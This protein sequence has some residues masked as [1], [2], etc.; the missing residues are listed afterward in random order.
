M[1]IRLGSTNEIVGTDAG[2]ACSTTTDIAS[3]SSIRLQEP[4]LSRMDAERYSLNTGHLVGPRQT[5]RI[6][7]QLCH[8]DDLARSPDLDLDRSDDASD[9]DSFR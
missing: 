4:R 1:S 9:I 6:R 5:I 8:G 7:E 3:D 2:L